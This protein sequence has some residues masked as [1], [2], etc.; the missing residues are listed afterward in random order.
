MPTFDAPI[1]LDYPDTPEPVDEAIATSGDAVDEVLDEVF[2]A[3]DED[4]D[5]EDEPIAASADGTHPDIQAL[6]D[7]GFR[8]SQFEVKTNQDGSFKSVEVVVGTRH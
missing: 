6:L 5:T 1:D 4:E 2:P 7:A 3:E 8:H